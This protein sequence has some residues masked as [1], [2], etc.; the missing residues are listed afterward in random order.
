MNKIIVYIDVNGRKNIDVKQAVYD[1][2]PKWK[3]E[4]V[5]YGVTSIDNRVCIK[6]AVSLKQK[7]R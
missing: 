3:Y 6:T 4:T 1:I 2:F 7:T 5:I